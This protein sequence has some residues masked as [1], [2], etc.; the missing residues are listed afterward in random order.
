[1]VPDIVVGAVV[2]FLGSVTFW[3]PRTLVLWSLCNW[4]CTHFG[5]AL[6]LFMPVTEQLEGVGAVAD[7]RVIMTTMAVP[8]SSGMQSNELVRH[9]SVDIRPRLILQKCHLHRAPWRTPCQANVVRHFG[10]LC[11]VEHG[12]ILVV[13]MMT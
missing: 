4:T 6:L 9:L 5:F 8:V 12:E 13:M 11:I 3:G 10:V 1:M 7:V 2:L